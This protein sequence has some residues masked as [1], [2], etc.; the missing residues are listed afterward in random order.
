MHASSEADDRQHEDVPVGR[1]R[2]GGPR[3][4]KSESRPNG[5]T[6]ARATSCT[7]TA[8]RWTCPPTPRT[9]AKKVKSPASTWLL[10]MGRHIAS[11]WPSATSS[12][13]TNLR[14]GIISTSPLQSSAR[15][16]SARNWWWIPE[17]ESVPGEVKIERAGTVLW[18]KTIRTGEKEMCHSLAN[19]EHHHFKFEGAPPPR[20]RSCTFFRRPIA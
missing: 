6:K 19:I 9:A 8:S 18:S 12:P 17:F 13:T 10:R 20:R 16:R 1:R 7:R 2:Q 3:P 15:A 5:F 4:G 14:R 11:A